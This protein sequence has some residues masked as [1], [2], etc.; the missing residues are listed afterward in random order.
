MNK[1]RF[2]NAVI[3][4]VLLMAALVLPFFSVAQISGRKIVDG[5]YY[6]SIAPGKASVAKFYNTRYI[7]VNDSVDG[8]GEITEI[9]NRAAKFLNVLIGI[10]L[11]RSINYI[12]D[13]AFSYCLSLRTLVVR[14]TTPPQMG[15]GVF[16]HTNTKACTLVVPDEAVA[17]Y[18]ADREWNSFG[19]IEGIRSRSSKRENDASSNKL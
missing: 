14:A 11:P 9:G 16:N 4:G 13:E 7:A 10:D 12:G 2:G 17:S 8:I 3:R 5:V 19:K 18:K 15:E 6:D 1:M